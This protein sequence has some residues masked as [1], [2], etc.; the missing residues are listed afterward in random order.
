MAGEEQLKLPG[1]AQNVILESRRR[2][3]VSGVEEVLTF[4]EN[5]V[6]MRTALG[7]LCVRGTELKV[8]RL[9]VESGDLVLSGQVSSLHYTEPPVSLWERLFG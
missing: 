1:R 7:E 8:E 5:T 4:D 3:S 6:L 2:M 9:A